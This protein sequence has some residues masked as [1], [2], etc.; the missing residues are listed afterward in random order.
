M[1]IQTYYPELGQANPGNKIEAEF[2]L[3]KYRVKTFE[4][5]A[6]QGIKFSYKI[7]AGQGIN[8]ERVGMNVYYLTPAAFKKLEKSQTVTL[9]IN[10]D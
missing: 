10:L 8:P 9:L 2:V 4:T 1:S 5:L 3:G 7:E 6:G